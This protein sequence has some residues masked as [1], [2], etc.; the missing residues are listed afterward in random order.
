MRVMTAV[1]STRSVKLL[2]ADPAQCGR[3]G[4]ELLVRRSLRVR[5]WLDAFDARVAAQ[6]ARLAAEGASADS[7]T[8][9]GG[10]G[11]RS[12]RDAEAAAARGD[13]CARMPGVGDALADGTVTAGHVDALVNA[14]RR[15]DDEARQRLAD[16]EASLLAAASS[17][18][19]E[20]FERECQ[21]LARNLTGDDGLSRHERMRRDRNVRRWVDR[22]TGMCKTLLSLDPLTDAQAWTAI[23]GAIAATRATNQ[24]GDER[25]WDQLVADVVVDLLRGGGT[26]T[27]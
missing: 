5:G 10:G 3:G 2:V 12:R 27:G 20:Q 19:P 9:L 7:A 24:T 13:V 6:A 22:H 14:A 1:C 16:H 15:L 11:R 18:T 8:V 21:H 25:S 4:L 17:L 23:N 26:A